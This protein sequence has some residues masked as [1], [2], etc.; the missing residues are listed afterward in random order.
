MTSKSILILFFILIISLCLPFIINVNDYIKE[1]YTNNKG[2]TNINVS[3]G[4]LLSGAGDYPYVTDS[5]LVQNQFPLTG[6]KEISNNTS[7]NLNSKLN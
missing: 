2:Y 3:T 1:G 6:N 4:T 5:L 7:N